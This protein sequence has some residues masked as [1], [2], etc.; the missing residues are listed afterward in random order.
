MSTE[1]TLV[2]VQKQIGKLGEHLVNQEALEQ[3]VKLAEDPDY[4][5]E[6]VELYHDS[7]NILRNA[8][9]P[10]H[11]QYLNAIKFYSLV[12]AENKL[13]D[14]YVKVFPERLA[15]REAK[16]PGKGYEAMHSEASRFNKSKLVNEIRSVAS[17]SVKLIYRHV[18]HEA[19]LSQAELMRTARS[20]MVRQ[21][22]GA[23]LI[24]ELR[25]EEDHQIN[26][27]VED[28]SAS[29]IDELRKAAEKLAIAE[30]T[31]VKAG[32]PLR[33]IANAKIIEGEVVEDKSDD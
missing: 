14:A 7:L 8:T 3:V 12:L 26:I 21:K 1:L 19:I 16:N 15:A 25:P 2:G 28:G 5:E 32:V 9:N 27:K 6:F 20:E 17:I 31:S 23:T 24:A 33:D 18:L 29:A 22:A 11:Q 4:G 13:T 10:N 30:H